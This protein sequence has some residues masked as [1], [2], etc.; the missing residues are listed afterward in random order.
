MQEELWREEVLLFVSMM[1]YIPPSL[2]ARVVACVA[3][4]GAIHLLLDHDI[5]MVIVV[6]MLIAHGKFPDKNI[7]MDLLESARNLVR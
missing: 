4:D 2:L 6:S 7:V 3:G 5:L 1:G